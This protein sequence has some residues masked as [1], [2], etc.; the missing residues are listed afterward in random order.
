MK[1]RAYFQCDDIEVYDNCVSAMRDVYKGE[2]LQHKPRLRGMKDNIELSYAEYDRLF[3][4]NDL[5]NIQQ[6]QRNVDERSSL[7]YLY[8]SNNNVIKKLKNNIRKCQDEHLQNICPNCGILPSN[9]VDHYIP[10]DQFFDFSIFPKNLIW[11]CG[12]CNSKKLN[13]WKE[14]AHRGIINFYL[15]NIPKF[16]FLKCEITSR[17]N[18][19]LR[20]KWDIIDEKLDSYPIV[21]QH[22]KRLDIIKLYNDHAPDKMGELVMQISAYKDVI[23]ED[24]VKK[25]LFKEFRSRIKLFGVND[26]KATLLRAFISGEFYKLYL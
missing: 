1:N 12:T 26:W 15:D 16:R 2:P 21:K 13:Y 20:A 24:Q 19:V 22:F 17:G 14:P 10:K 25:I 4:V 23:T 18:N 6:P 3:N 11:I 8:E 5:I 9:T 7:I